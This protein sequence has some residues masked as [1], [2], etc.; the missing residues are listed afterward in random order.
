MICNS[1]EA[2]LVVMT[3]LHVAGRSGHRRIEE[4]DLHCSQ[5]LDSSSK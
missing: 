5:R 1:D 4:D 2:V 3:R